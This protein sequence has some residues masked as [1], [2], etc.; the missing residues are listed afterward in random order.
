[1]FCVIMQYGRFLFIA[2]EAILLA[3]R[4]VVVQELKVEQEKPLVTPLF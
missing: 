2:A 1:M 4:S 3:F